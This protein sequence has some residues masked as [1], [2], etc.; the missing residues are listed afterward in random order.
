MSG[1]LSGCGFVVDSSVVVKWF[2]EDREPDV[3]AALHLLDAHEAGASPLAAP[4]LLVLEFV[5][6]LSR[7]GASAADLQLSV[8]DLLAM[9]LD[10]VS[11][12][13]VVHDVS[14]L[15]LRFS[16]TTY[17]ASFAA[18]ANQLAVPLVTADRRLAQS[19]ACEAILLG[20]LA[21]SS[22]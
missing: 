12:T 17:D 16:L 18:L 11:V 5:N 20:E 3:A 13:H 15:C 2:V 9:H 4:D 22:D 10:L 6:A 21:V 14:S 7:R 19:G 1:S 8:G